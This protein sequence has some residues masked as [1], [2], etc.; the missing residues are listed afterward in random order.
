MTF[1]PDL[2]RQQAQLL[3][4]TCL[5]EAGVEQAHMEARLIMQHCTQSNAIN[6]ITHADAPLGDD[7]LYIQSMLARRLQHKP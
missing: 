6:L 1:T 7:Y 3:I 4:S 2:S 5:A